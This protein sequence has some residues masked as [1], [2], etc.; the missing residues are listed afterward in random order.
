MIADVVRHGTPWEALNVGAEALWTHR[1]YISRRFQKISFLAGRMKAGVGWA[2]IG[3][4]VQCQVC[5]TG[6]RRR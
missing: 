4:Q 5:C 3:S 6:I 2:G 1:Q